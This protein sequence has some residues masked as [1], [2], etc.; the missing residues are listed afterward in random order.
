MRVGHCEVVALESALQPRAQ[1]VPGGA[2][3]AI[4]ADDPPEPAGSIPGRR[5]HSH[6]DAVAIL[7]QGSQFDTALNDDAEFCCAF[8]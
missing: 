4:S 2:V 3:A 8:L 1:Q 5:A 6:I 7:R